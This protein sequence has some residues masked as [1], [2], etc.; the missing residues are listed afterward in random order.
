M[1]N[2]YFLLS[3]LILSSCKTLA[4]KQDKEYFTDLL[5]Y[6]EYSLIKIKHSRGG[7][8]TRNETNLIYLNNNKCKVHS[9]IQEASTIIDTVFILSGAQLML[10]NSLYENLKEERMESHELIIAGTIT[11]YDINI[12]GLN[13]RYYNK[14]NYSL[15]EELIKL[16]N[17]PNGAFK[18]Q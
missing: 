17:V 11:T 12:S 15:F 14:I 18:Q 3:L 16:D 4:Q 7:G 9:I 10:I 8:Y 2:I 5:N 1:R 6:G 13:K